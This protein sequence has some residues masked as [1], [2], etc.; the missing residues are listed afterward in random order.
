[1]KTDDYLD[2]G[3]EV[4]VETEENDED[5]EELIETEPNE[6][7]ALNVGEDPTADKWISWVN[8]KPIKVRNPTY[9]YIHFLAKAANM[10]S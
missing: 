1:M 8:D 3:A 4:V 7:N 6:L 10:T 2:V 9:V 5:I